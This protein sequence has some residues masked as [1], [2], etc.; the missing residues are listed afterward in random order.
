MRRTFSPVGLVAN[1]LVV[2]AVTVIPAAWTGSSSVRNVNTS[3]TGSPA[4][5]SRPVPVVIT[6]P[7]GPACSRVRQSVAVPATAMLRTTRAPSI[8]R[9]VPASVRSASPPPGGPV[10]STVTARS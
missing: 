8:S 1:G 7:P 4:R 9:A 2:R 3:G 6:V 10:A 5:S